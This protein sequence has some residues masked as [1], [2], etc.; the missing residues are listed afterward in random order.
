MRKEYVILTTGRCASELLVAMLKQ[1]DHIVSYPEIFIGL[2]PSINERDK[3]DE[4]LNRIRREA[5]GKDISYKINGGQVK[6]HQAYLLNGQNVKVIFLYRK[7][8]FDIAISIYLASLT[9]CWGDYAER[10][11]NGTVVDENKI[12]KAMIGIRNQMDGFKKMIIESGRPVLKLV[13]PDYITNQVELMKYVDWHKHF[14]LPPGGRKPWATKQSGPAL[15]AKIDNYL[16][17]K[18]RFGKEEWDWNA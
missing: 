15:Y 7:K 16:E 18:E 8:I 6:K 2:N 13:Y 4:I 5:G 10:V 17:L 12:N 9:K 14:G 11:K 3:L 1:V